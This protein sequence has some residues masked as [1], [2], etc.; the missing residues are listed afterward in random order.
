MK[1]TSNTHLSK[2]ERTEKCTSLFFFLADRLVCQA[3]R[4]RGR[5]TRHSETSSSTIDVLFALLRFNFSTDLRLT[6]FNR[7]RF[8]LL[9]PESATARMPPSQAHPSRETSFSPPTLLLQLLLLFPSLLPI[10]AFLTSPLYKSYS[11]PPIPSVGA[12]PISYTRQPSRLILSSW[13][14]TKVEIEVPATPEACYALYSQLEEH[15]RWSP[16]LRS[17]QFLDKV[18]RISEWTLESRGFTVAWKAQ[19][20]IEEPGRRISW[21]SRTGL[22][23]RGLVTFEERRPGMTSM[24]LTISYSV[25]K[26]IAKLGD[27]GLVKRYIESTLQSDLT[28]YRQVLMKEIREKRIEASGGLDE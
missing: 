2:K 16:W 15:P 20:T 8:P 6:I 22:P 24:A 21:E 23:N 10:T 25:P 5:R 18:E 27:V 13:V 11:F 28:R 12:S 7:P 3:P 19:N 4:Q 14:D 9:A 26:P 1:Y 17:V